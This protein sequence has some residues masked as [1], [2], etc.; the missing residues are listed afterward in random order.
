MKTNAS[1][2]QCCMETSK[3][4]LSQR[5]TSTAC[6]L[7]CQLEKCDLWG[8]RD[9]VW[10]VSPTCDMKMPSSCSSSGFPGGL[11]TPPWMVKPNPSPR[12]VLMDSSWHWRNGETGMW[13]PEFSIRHGFKLWQ[14]NS[15]LSTAG[16]VGNHSFTAMW[17]LECSESSIKPT[18]R[19]LFR[20]HQSANNLL[21]SFI[22]DNNYYGMGLCEYFIVQKLSIQPIHSVDRAARVASQWLPLN[23]GYQDAMRPF[24]IPMGKVSSPC[25]P[26]IQLEPARGV[27]PATPCR[28]VLQ[29][30]QQLGHV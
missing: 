17:L 1:H 8:L 10:T 29:A 12:V 20:I 9:D 13:S 3:I 23:F 14:K 6:M 26:A 16:W 15:K 28:V 11:S 22:T 2:P 5:K 4:V 19:F 24:P 25:S 18:N 30:A 27:Q 7:S 21:R